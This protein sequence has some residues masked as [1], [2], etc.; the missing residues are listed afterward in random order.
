MLYQVDIRRA[1]PPQ[2]V[3]EFWQAEV[4]AA[5]DVK[6]Y[7]NKLVEGTLRH[8][9]DI[10]MPGMSSMPSRRAAGSATAR[11]SVLSWS[12]M[13]IAESPACLASSTTRS[14]DSIPSE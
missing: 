2:V 6:S 14:G 12:V 8:L 4:Q 13:A 5:D 10:S 7:A 3:E 1:E 11:A 9:A